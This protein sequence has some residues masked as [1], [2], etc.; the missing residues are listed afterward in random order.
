MADVIGE[1]TFARRFGFMDALED[2]GI[3]DQIQRSVRSGVWLA[4]V[5]YIL[6]L[7]NWFM[8]IIGN[9]LAINDRNGT[10]R[11][12]TVREVDGRFDRGSDRPDILGKLIS[13][14]KER[15]VEMSK[16]NIVSVA[17]SNIGAGSDTTAI[18]LRAILFFLLRNP[19]KLKALLGEIDS[20][21]RE[22]NII[23]V[24]SFAQA[25]KMPYL[26]AVM[27]EAMRLY[28]AIGATLPRIT[29]HGG[30]VIGERFIPAGVR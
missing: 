23:D 7:H 9:H 6:R 26:Q 28:P 27:Y 18:S 19:D 24:F 29:P 4:H 5:P 1:I 14:N 30:L 12:Y 21:V 15:P 25:S 10:I 16:N 8:P 13:I 20:M 11:D 2:D 3:F 17:G 22:E